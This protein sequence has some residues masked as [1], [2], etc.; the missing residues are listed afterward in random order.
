[1]FFDSQEIELTGRAL[2]Q[3]SRHEVFAYSYSPSPVPF[4]KSLLLMPGGCLKYCS[5]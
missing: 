2:C 1:M 4:Y 5:L 3:L